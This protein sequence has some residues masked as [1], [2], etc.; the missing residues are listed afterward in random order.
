MW[1]KLVSIIC[2]IISIIMCVFLIN[3]CIPYYKSIMAKKELNEQVLSEY[4][5]TELPATVNDS[6]KDVTRKEIDFNKLQAI[7]PDIIGWISAP[8]IN[9]DYPILRGETNTYYLNKDYEKNY[10]ALGSIFTWS[11]TDEFLEDKHIVLFG[12]N[13]IG[14]QM[15]GGLKDYL[16]ADFRSR[17]PHIDIY[18]PT[19]HM[20]LEVTDVKIVSKNDP[21][22]Q[23]DYLSDSLD[24]TFIL[25]SC[26]GPQG[27]SKRIVVKCKVVD[28]QENY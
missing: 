20:T 17:N 5:Y 21:I 28:T 10:N 19:K 24:Q 16:N 9:V 15:F 8:Q 2:L 11:E 26:H 13:G 22:L 4:T 27:T 25:S 14:K 18:T 12:H 6:T 23:P 3:E 7:N 1:K